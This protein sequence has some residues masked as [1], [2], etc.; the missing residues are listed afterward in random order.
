[1]G[2]HE[3]TAAA[4]WMFLELLLW[5]RCL[6]STVNAT[7]VWNVV[8]FWHLWFS[9]GILMDFVARPDSSIIFNN[10][11]FLAQ[12]SDEIWWDI[13]C[14][15]VL[16]WVLCSQVD[17]K[18]VSSRQTY[19]S[20]TA[21]MCSCLSAYTQQAKVEKRS[22]ELSR[23]DPHPLNWRLQVLPI[24]DSFPRRLRSSIWPL[25]QFSSF[26]VFMAKYGQL[27]PAV[28]RKQGGM[29]GTASSSPDLVLWLPVR[30]KPEPKIIGMLPVPVCLKL[31]GLQ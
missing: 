23:L 31:L 4:R 29:L 22:E 10:D 26:Q 19:S 16:P 21:E 12:L 1:M 5:S 2:L 8:W 24:S 3:E 11:V 7:N 15:T 9:G 28:E 13:T 18:Q 25:S 17:T 27:R 14:A 30:C 20:L 6:N